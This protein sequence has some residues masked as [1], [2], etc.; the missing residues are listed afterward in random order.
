MLIK[1]QE[2]VRTIIGTSQKYH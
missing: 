2:K 1:N